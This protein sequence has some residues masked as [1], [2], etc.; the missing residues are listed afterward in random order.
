MHYR[1]SNKPYIS[2]K[3]YMDLLI[4]DNGEMG[5][6]Q[7]RTFISSRALTISLSHTK[8]IIDLAPDP[9]ALLISKEDDWYLR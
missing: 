4:S 3:S 6:K 5:K 7:K 1:S 9:S 8:D 2:V